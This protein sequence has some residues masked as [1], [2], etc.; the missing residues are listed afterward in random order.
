M[1]YQIV[2]TDSKYEESESF[3]RAVAIGDWIYVSHCAGRNYATG[4][5]SDTVEGQTR[6]VIENVEN[7][8]KAV[9]ASLKDVVHRVVTIPR[10]EQAAEV[11]SIVGEAF[12]DAT[13]TNTVTCAPLGGPDYV[14]EMEV[15]A[16]R[17]F[18]A[19]EKEVIK[20]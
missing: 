4:F 8:L 3:V 19:A 20:I 18:G 2:R 6:Q 10:V 14:L 9:G 15:T 13:A 17:G 1:T 11:M 5:M 16:Y 12:R 7:A